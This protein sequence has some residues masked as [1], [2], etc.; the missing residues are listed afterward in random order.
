MPDYSL[1]PTTQGTQFSFDDFR[2]SL[3][4]G[5]SQPISFADLYTGG[6]YVPENNNYF[7]FILDVPPSGEISLRNFQSNYSLSNLTFATPDISNH[8]EDQV[9]RTLISIDLDTGHI[10]IGKKLY[11]ELEPNT[12]TS[13]PDFTADDVVSMTGRIGNTLTGLVTVVSEGNVAISVSF[14]QDLKAEGDIALRIKLPGLSNTSPI[15]TLDYTQ[16]VANVLSDTSDGWTNHDFSSTAYTT[17]TGVIRAISGWRFDLDDVLTGNP[18]NTGYGPY[19]AGYTDTNFHTDPT[20]PSQFVQYQLPNSPTPNPS[21]SIYGNVSGGDLYGAPAPNSVSMQF[22]NS[23]GTGLATSITAGSPPTDATV[24]IVNL[25]K[26]SQ[27]CNAA[28]DITSG[29]VMTADT[30]LNLDTSMSFQFDYRTIVSGSDRG[31]TLVYL[32]RDN[33]D[34]QIILDQVSDLSGG[35]NPG[36]DTVTIP[37]AVA[38]KYTPVFLFRI[39]DNDGNSS[40]SGDLFVANIRLV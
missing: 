14:K 40:S 38:G 4:V 1:F 29:P 8:Q 9:V 24:N 13:D 16:I 33:G 35:S 25:A 28:Y 39:F 30:W 6:V 37:I 31:A 22:I 32:Q 27:T 15:G 36:W 5:N 34:H 3:D 7:T 26:I 18:T 11:Y 12:G 19:A 10:P 21:S 2:S 23:T 17:N 20:N